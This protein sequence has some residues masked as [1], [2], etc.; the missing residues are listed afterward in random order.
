M[1][2]CSILA[3]LSLLVCMAGCTG[4]EAGEPQGSTPSGI[5]SPAPSS[6]PAGTAPIE[7]GSYLVP[8]SAWSVADFTVTFPRGWTVQDG[9]TYLKHSG[10]DREVGF[11]AVEVSEIFADACKSGEDITQV[12]PSIYDLA[13]ALLK[14][15]G[16]RALE[17]GGTPAMDRGSLGGY[18][19]ILIDLDIPK[20]LNLRACNL[21]GAGLQV[22][23]SAP[24]DAY[25]VLL[26]DGLAWVYILNVE[27]QRQVFV[28][29]H[30]SAASSKDMRQLEEVLDSIQIQT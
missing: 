6:I 10:T 16:P 30:R 1:R 8:A 11:Y 18:P 21:Q 2:T 27:G 29:Q 26:P 5:P 20:N 15:P 28:A 4:I 12:G 25:F 19:A 3:G 24:A 23:Y 17:G 9:H 22:W 13:G 14:Q 7:P